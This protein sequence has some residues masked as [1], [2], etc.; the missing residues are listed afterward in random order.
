MEVRRRHLE[1]ESD[2]ACPSGVT[3]RASFQ[4]QSTPPGPAAPGTRLIRRGNGRRGYPIIETIRNPNSTFING[5]AVTVT[6]TL[7]I[8]EVSEQA[9]AASLFAVPPGSRP[10][11]RI[12][13]GGSDMSRPDTL[14]N[15]AVVYWQ[16]FV[17]WTNRLV[18]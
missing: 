9:L 8:V 14:V 1:R 18:R 11:L 5:A 10:A 4:P 16:A 17:A 2:R 6:S 13:G 12:P 3:K 15:R 7:D